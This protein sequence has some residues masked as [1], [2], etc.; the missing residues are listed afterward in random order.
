MTYDVLSQQQKCV[1]SKIWIF[2]DGD[3]I[4]KIFRLP[5]FILIFLYSIK[6]GILKL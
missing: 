2:E 5:S 6:K 1:Y 3:G 4:G